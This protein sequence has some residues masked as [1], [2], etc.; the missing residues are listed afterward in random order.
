L[1][2]LQHNLDKLPKMMQGKAKSQLH[3]IY[4]APTNEDAEMAYNKFI[5]LPVK[6]PQSC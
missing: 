4:L 2:A 1:G 6:V 5:K 3:D